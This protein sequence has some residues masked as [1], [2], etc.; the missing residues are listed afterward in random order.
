MLLMAFVPAVVAAA[1]LYWI[2]RD[3]TLLPLAMTPA[4]VAIVFV[5]SL[6]MAAAS[7]LLSVGFL[8]RAAPAD[9]F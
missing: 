5:A 1:G 2:I 4:R 6:V 7:A 9:V 8:R 3:Q